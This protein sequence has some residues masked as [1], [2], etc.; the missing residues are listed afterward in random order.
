MRRR[1]IILGLL[2]VAAVGTV[3]A[4][5]SKKA[6]RIAIV[7][8]SHPLVQLMEANGSPLMKEIFRNSVGRDMSRGRIS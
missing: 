6:H 1:N 2:A 5:E 3:Y 8:P 7:H 4:Q